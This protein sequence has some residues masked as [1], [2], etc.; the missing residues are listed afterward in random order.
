V[1]EDDRLLKSLG[2][3]AREQEAA[4]VPANLAQPPTIDAVENLIA[5]TLASPA[6]TATPPRRRR[7]R[8]L[9][10]LWGALILPAAL[11]SV[12]LMWSP[13][14]APL[15]SY[16]ATI[17]GGVAEV[18]SSSPASPGR[19]VIAAGVPV[20]VALRPRDA[21]AGRLEVRAFWRRQDE[22]QPW[23]SVAVERSERGSV[24]L[25]GTGQRPFGSGEGELVLVVGRA[26]TVPASV[27][28]HELSAPPPQWRVVSTPV[29]WR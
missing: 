20:E 10:T 19:V 21:V 25:R 22:V 18:R 12:W 9:L 17:T 14:Q 13:G 4:T 24:R 29:T 3:L 6:A 15:P 27:P 23:S 2:A 26:G 1:K 28:A 8:S 16:Q 7:R 11:A 5:T